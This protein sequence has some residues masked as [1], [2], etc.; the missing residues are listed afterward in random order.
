[1]FTRK[2]PELPHSRLSAC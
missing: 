2:V 1:M